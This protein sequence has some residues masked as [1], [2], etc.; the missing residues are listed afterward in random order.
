M[1]RKNVYSQVYVIRILEI[2]ENYRVP[3]VQEAVERLLVFSS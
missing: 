2:S 3:R 1:A